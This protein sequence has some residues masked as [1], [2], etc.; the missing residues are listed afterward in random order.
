MHLHIEISILKR[1]RSDVQKQ[2]IPCTPYVFWPSK[3]DWMESPFS[4]TNA[5][6]GGDREEARALAEFGRIE[7]I[8]SPNPLGAFRVVKYPNQAGIEK[9]I[10]YYV[11]SM[12]HWAS[13]SPCVHLTGELTA[14]DW[15]RHDVNMN[16]GLPVTNVPQD[17][18]LR[19]MVSQ[20]IQTFFTYSYGG[21]PVFQIPTE[22][23]WGPAPTVERIMYSN[24]HGADVL[25]R[26]FN[27]RSFS[28]SANRLRASL[29]Q[30]GEQ[31]V[32]AS[33]SKSEKRALEIDR[34]VT[35]H[36]SNYQLGDRI[37]LVG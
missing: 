26:A 25:A 24:Y 29:S 19:Q 30:E 18:A 14:D 5:M 15:A 23:I 13:G 27:G 12:H 20:G 36:R 21:T 31:A 33:L 8:P 1:T 10:G 7:E 9:N 22:V 3:D 37:L 11:P 34:P 35:I 28:T 2:E 6:R 4:L 32:F 17:V 16:D